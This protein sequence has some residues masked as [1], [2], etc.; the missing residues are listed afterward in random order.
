MTSYTI[1]QFLAIMEFKDVTNAISVKDSFKT[2]AEVCK[3]ILHPSKLAFL[4]WNWTFELSYIICIVISLY[5]C[6]MVLAGNK[7]H[8]KYVA[9]GVVGYFFMNILNEVIVG[10][11]Q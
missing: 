10:V 5:G 3:Y 2:I 4:L 9:G 1:P 11:F 6:F 7:G 8:K